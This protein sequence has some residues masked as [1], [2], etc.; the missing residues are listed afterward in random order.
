MY[1]T[2]HGVKYRALPSKP[3]RF[4]SESR[5]L[6]SPPSWIA[7]K[8]S[9]GRSNQISG[10]WHPTPQPPYA[11]DVNQNLDRTLRPPPTSGCESV[12]SKTFYQKSHFDSVVGR[13]SANATSEKIPPLDNTSFRKWLDLSHLPQPPSTS[14]TALASPF[15]QKQRLRRLN[16][17]KPESSN[18]A[19][20][21]ATSNQS[22]LRRSSKS[23]I[24]MV[25]N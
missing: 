15:W 3:P 11:G 2:P 24:R 23:G 9:L 6:E 20:S 25:R 10:S 21:P 8:D 1:E 16:H 13:S 12:T 14:K 4:A 19:V 17:P 7:S 18:G 22:N 5:I